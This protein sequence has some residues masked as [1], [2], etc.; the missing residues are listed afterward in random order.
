MVKHLRSLNRF[1]CQHQFVRR[2]GRGR[3]WLECT[4]CGHETPGIHVRVPGTI[5]PLTATDQRAMILGA[6]LATVRHS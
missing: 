3:L 6:A 5:E 2:F 1:F 4:S